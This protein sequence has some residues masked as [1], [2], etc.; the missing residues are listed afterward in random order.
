[1]QHS[2]GQD[3]SEDISITMQNELDGV[4]DSELECSIFRIHNLL[5]KVNESAYEP[6]II[7][8]GPY[9]HRK[10]DLKSMK[11]HKLLYLKL[12][13]RQ[14]NTDVK[15]C[16]EAVEP[17]ERDARKYYAEPIG[18]EL[19]RQEF[20][21][22][23]VLDGCFII[24]LLLYFERMDSVDRND[25]IF[26]QDWILNSLQRD[27][28]L[29]ENQLPFFILCKLYETLELPNEEGGLI[30]LALNFFIDLLPVQVSAIKNGNALYNIR[31][32]LDENRN[33]LDDIRH[34]LDLIHRFWSTSKL[35]PQN[36]AERS[37]G[38]HESIRFSTQCHL[39]DLIHRYWSTPKVKPQNDMKRS[40]EESELIPCSTQLADAGIELLKIDQVDIFDIQFDNGSLQIP[41]LVIEDRTESFLRNLI[42]YEQYSGGG[43]YV[44]DYVTFLGC[45]IKS[46]KDVTKLSHHGIIHNR[47]G[48]NEVISQMLNKMIV[49]IVGPSSN[50]HYAEICSRVNIHCSRPVNRWRATLRRKYCNSPW[51]II[52]I[53]AASSLLILTLLQTTFTILSWKSPYFDKLRP[54]VSLSKTV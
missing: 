9:H 27:L 21:K 49:C 36:D 17:L 23:M 18:P 39:P 20:V 54:S 12:L 14:K 28:M 4:I 40:T 8:I 44:T 48:E 35:K 11:D 7:A 41:T 2:E 5:R 52:S 19:S 29:L 51:G 43:G 24:K 6:E 25:P 31:H 22:M 30:S 42:A 50:S 45:L 53:I 26:K 15:K 47:I 32:L 33:P 10:S 34:L 38:G 3:V 16:V 13:L 46:K 37:T 1:M